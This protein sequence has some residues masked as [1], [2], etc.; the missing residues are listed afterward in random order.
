MPLD[1][2]DVGAYVASL[3]PE[4]QSVILDSCANYVRNPVDAKAGNTVTF[5]QIAAAGA[6]APASDVRSFASTAPAFVAA[7]PAPAAAPDAANVMTN[8]Q[9]GIRYRVFPNDS[10]KGS[11]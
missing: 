8:G 10:S 2:Q 9:S 5:C 3:A 1:A 7:P 11:F 4:T 6:P